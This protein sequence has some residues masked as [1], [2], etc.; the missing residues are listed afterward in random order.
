MSELYEFGKFVLDPKKRTLLW[1]RSPVHLTPKTFDILLVLL[2]NPNRVVSKDELMKAVWPDT[3][4]EEGNLTFNISVLRK[5]LLEHAPGER[6]IVTLARQ[7]YQFTADV[8][9]ADSTEPPTPAS[10]IAAESANEV[11]ER[12]S[13]NEIEPATPAPTTHVPGGQSTREIRQRKWTIVGLV[14][15]IML[16]ASYLGWRSSR[17]SLSARSTT[18]LAVLP[19]LNL[20]GDPK[21]EYLADGITE[22]LISRLAQLDP[23]KL[24]VIAR[25]SVMGYKQPGTPLEEIARDLGVQRVLESSVRGGPGRLRI[26][27]QLIDVRNQSHLWSSDYDYQSG[28]ILGLEEDVATAVAQQIQLGL[29]SRR[30]TDSARS[31]AISSG[32]IDAYL[33]GHYLFQH[34]TKDN[35]NQAVTYFEH[36]ITLDSMYALAWV[37]LSGA[38]RR[39]VEFGFTPP[40][41]YRQARE[42]AERALALDDGLGIAYANL[43]WIQIN[44]DWDWQGANTSVQRA[45]HL[46]PGNAAILIEASALSAAL[47]RN[48]EALTEARRTEELDPLNPYVHGWLGLLLL[49]L[50]RPQEAAVSLQRLMQLRSDYPLAHGELALAYL[51]EGHAQDAL[52]ESEKEQLPSWRMRVEAL[53][54][55]TLG[56]RHESDSILAELTAQH[57]DHAAYQ[58]AEVYA[59]R[60]EPDQA[61]RWLGRA[62]AQRDPGLSTTKADP[63][64]TNLRGDPRYNAFLARLHLPQ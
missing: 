32:A 45:L 54:H 49:A 6:L 64:L 24:S 43:G 44:H 7:G 4:V 18:R 50:N 40:E 10:T 17:P 12:V 19:C 53:A 52:V 38:Q 62:Y 26:T 30:P 5:T 25:T 58:I 1:D 51:F 22:E 57:Q 15:S 9:V 3:F 61:F 20:T 11:A 34:P 27:V 16:V 41:G 35:L 60:G 21:Q 13:A 14:V 47:G 63:L 56:R 2:R 59:Y 42:S 8:A 31:H 28:E 23:Q 36:A 46:D 37:A 29:A 39:Q 33:Q 48:D 55:Y